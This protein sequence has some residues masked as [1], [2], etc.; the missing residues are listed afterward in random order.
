M[1]K[2]FIESDYLKIQKGFR[3]RQR[4][5][6][7]K[8]P[9]ECFYEAELSYRIYNPVINSR[10]TKKAHIKITAKTW[11]FI[12]ITETTLTLDHSFSDGYVDFDS[13]DFG[14][15]IYFKGGVETER[16]RF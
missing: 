16:A 1:K 9:G 2:T 8:E 3:V 11:S 14:T 12:E 10:E 15:I 6:L 4:D 13:K 5:F 7:L